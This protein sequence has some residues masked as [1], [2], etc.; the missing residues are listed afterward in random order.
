MD[1]CLELPQALVQRLAWSTQDRI[2]PKG[3]DSPPPLQGRREA[4]M[5]G[6]KADRHLTDPAPDHSWFR[7]TLIP[8]K[9]S[10]PPLET[11]RS[12]CNF[13]PYP[14]HTYRD[15]RQALPHVQQVLLH[16]SPK[17]LRFYSIRIRHSLLRLCACK[18][19]T[20]AVHWKP[21]PWGLNPWLPAH[22]LAVI[23]LNILVPT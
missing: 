18:V 4:Q 1:Q 11:A 10:S 17:A 8:D 5:R 12:L 13:S 23:C 15:S 9:L 19:Q 21:K 14:M 7:A 3:S 20:C 6:R 22:G 2:L 16:S